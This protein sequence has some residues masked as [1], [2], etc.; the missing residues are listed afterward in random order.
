MSKLG[1]RLKRGTRSTCWFCGKAIV[2][3]LGYTGLDEWFH[4]EGGFNVCA[5]PVN[6]L[7]TPVLAL[8]DGEPE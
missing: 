1:A 6:G 8:N 4:E 2:F 3:D 7:A 5:F